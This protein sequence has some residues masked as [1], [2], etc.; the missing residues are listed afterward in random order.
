MSIQGKIESCIYNTITEVNILLPD[1]KKIDNNLDAALFG[2]HSKLDSLNVINFIVTLEREVKTQFEIA[3]FSLLDGTI[4]D[5]EIGS[6]SNGRE[7]LNFMQ[8]KIEV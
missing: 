8:K 6:I 7:L 2:K 1:N 4:L 5:Q 3:E